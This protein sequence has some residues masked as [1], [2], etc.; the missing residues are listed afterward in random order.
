MIVVRKT[1]V[2]IV[3]VILLS[4]GASLT[5]AQGQDYRG[6]FRTVRQLI[7]KIDNRAGVF[8]NNMRTALASNTYGNNREENMGNLV[9]EFDDSAS[10]L[11]GQFDNRR[12]TTLQAQEVL[13]IG[14]R[15]DRFMRRNTINAA[16]TRD[17]TNLR[18]DLTQLA[19]AYNVAF[20]T[21]GRNNPG[22]TPAYPGTGQYSN[23]LTGTYRL[24]TTKSD[25]PH[26]AADRATQS[27]A[28]GNRS[29]V[30]EELVA[31]LE[32]PDQLAID[33]R[34]RDVTIGSSRAPQISFTAD[35]VQR[36]ENTGNGRTTR[37]SATLNAEQLTISSTGDLANEFN[38]TF[39]PI[40]NGSRLS[41]TRRVYVTGLSRQVAVQSIYE[42]TADIARFDINTGPQ[43]YPTTT[44]SGTDFI[45][46]NGETLVAV[47]NDEVSTA[48]AREGDGFTLTVRQP[49]NLEGA[50][51]QG[52]VS[53]LERS[54][55][56]TGRSQMTL[57]FDSIR[58]RDGR[59]YRFAGILESVRTAQGDTVRIDNEGSVRDDS[60]TTKTAQRAAIGTAV[61]AII[62]AIAGGGKGAAIGAIVGAGGGA[63]SVYVQ[64][65]DDLELTRGSELTIRASGPR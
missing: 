51:I 7:L 22:T 2:A 26:A 31:R 42:K 17:W 59:S 19:R 65:R 39:N 5:Q 49:S 47:L 24:D 57:N 18:L 6:T 58:L 10:R 41:V 14:S 27:L 43:S 38:V 12:S 37:A 15:I 1:L 54:G 63:G 50:T 48:N 20:P 16:T 32:S 8:G 28:Y 11:R 40:D 44:T 9:Q 53:Q 56:V 23:R 52:R 4:A 64:G 13:N 30:R 21:M 35:G 60:Q 61:G 45:V 46:P 36:V 33:V 29:R 25:D 3:A 55:R 62:G 34:G